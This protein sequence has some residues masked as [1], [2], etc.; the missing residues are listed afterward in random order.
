MP[1]VGEVEHRGIT[2]EGLSSTLLLAGLVQK[3][4]P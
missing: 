3:V 4:P 2:G 1:V